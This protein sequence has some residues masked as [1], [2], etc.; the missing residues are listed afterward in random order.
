MTYVSER[1][2]SGVST[3]SAEEAADHVPDD[4]TVGMSSLGGGPKEVPKHVGS[5][6][7][8]LTLLGTADTGIVADYSLIDE[9]ELR[10]PFAVWQ[11]V[12]DA[13]NEGRMAFVDSHL[14]HVP[15]EVRQ[16]YFG[17]VDVAVVEAVAVGEDWLIPSTTVG[18]TPT[19][20]EA[21]DRVVVEVNHGQPLALQRFHDVYRSRRDEHLPLESPGE[22]LG[23]P[24]IEFPADELAAVVETDAEPPGYPFRDLKPEEEEI[25]E[26]FGEF[27]EDEVE[28]NPLLE[29]F[30]SFEVGVGS[31]GDAVS[32]SLADVE[33]GDLDV[34][35]YSE[36]LQDGV[37]DLLDD[38][39]L[40][41]ASAMSMVLSEDGK[42][43]VFDDIERYA[44]DVVLRPLSVS[45]DADAIRRFHVVAVNAAVEVDIYG[46][47]N[48]SHVRGSTLL[49]GIGGSADF[50]RHSL[51]SVF[52]LSSTVKDGEISTIVPM[53]THVD[54]TEHD[55]DVVV[56][57]HGVADVRGLPPRERAEAIID[58]CAH[59]DYRDRLRRYV[60]DAEE[61]GGH[62]P[63][64]LAE[65]FESW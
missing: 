43:Q 24:K 25:V 19:Y 40:K 18:A 39:V 45:N 22:R 63:H 15:E 56:T 23:G 20:V 34:H 48:S 58:K 1:V 35:L 64:D 59:P 12:K 9:V 28:R 4:G 27:V 61:G 10:Y 49:Q 30:V 62:V 57:E 8:E 60:E 13:I 36:V 41:E 51:V 46:N 7:G 26:Q 21:A 50:S 16:R 65:S 42:Q 33:F 47:V 2:A 5:P 3:V 44:E 37:L 31:L 53:A 17:D 29:D 6:D 32:R 14:S 38:G 11:P 54:H 52:V 55:V